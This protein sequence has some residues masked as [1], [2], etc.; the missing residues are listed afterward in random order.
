MEEGWVNIYCSILVAAEVTTNDAVLSVSI[1]KVPKEN[2]EVCPR[3]CQAN[4]RPRE[5]LTIATCWNSVQNF[6]AIAPYRMN[7]PELEELQ[8]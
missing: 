5:R 3:N 4:L 7:P 2:K 8:K 1:T 6:M